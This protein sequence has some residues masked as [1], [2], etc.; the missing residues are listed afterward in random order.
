MIIST[1]GELFYQAIS[2]T[3]FIS[4]SLKWFIITL[5]IY[6]SNFRKPLSILQKSNADKFISFIISSTYISL[7]LPIKN[8]VSIAHTNIDLINISF[9]NIFEKSIL[10]YYIFY[11]FYNS[12]S[13]ILNESNLASLPYYIYN[14]SIY[15]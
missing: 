10:V 7:T 11:S 9:I 12:S 3:I 8:I 2:L 5:G 14:N 1:T 15:F 4:I 6:G 13:N